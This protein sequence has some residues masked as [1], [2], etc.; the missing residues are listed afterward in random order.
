MGALA[1]G[2]RLALVHAGVSA[3]FRLAA[4]VAAGAVL[5]VALLLWRERELVAEIWGLVRRR[6][7]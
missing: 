1:Y 5:Y 4:V 2:V 6:G 3:G 7:R